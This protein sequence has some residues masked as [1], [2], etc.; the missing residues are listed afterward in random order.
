V[1]QRR[2]G[3]RIVADAAA[4]P[5][6]MI[7]IGKRSVLRLL[8]QIL[9]RRRVKPTIARTDAEIDEPVSIYYVLLIYL[10]AI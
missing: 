4:T 9:S 1:A 10:S 3:C 5:I 7:L 2:T 8:R 6:A